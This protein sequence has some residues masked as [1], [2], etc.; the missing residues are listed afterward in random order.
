MRTYPHPGKFET[1][2][3]VTPALYDYV[4][5]GADDECGDVTACGFFAWR[6][7]SLCAS[8]F[9]ATARIEHGLTDSDVAEACESAGAIV[10][11]DEQGFVTLQLFGTRV[12]L[13]SRWN[14]LESMASEEG[15]A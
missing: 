8:D 13:E 4:Q 7:N 3:I 1:Q 2:P 5:C 9:Y 11:E 15:D 10:L 14:R 12:A 6:L